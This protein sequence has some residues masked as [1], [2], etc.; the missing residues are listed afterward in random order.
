MINL[1]V[2]LGGIIRSYPVSSM[3]AQSPILQV[4]QGYLHR[5]T[6]AVVL[7]TQ[8]TMRILLKGQCNVYHAK[9]VPL[10]EEVAALPAGRQ[11]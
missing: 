1:P 11:A 10:Q 7:E 4:G 3:D 5:F 6:D 9:V 8:R 2:D